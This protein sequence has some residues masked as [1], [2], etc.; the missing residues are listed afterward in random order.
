MISK[1]N[2]LNGAGIIFSDDSIGE[3]PSP[4]P[5]IGSTI[6]IS[7]APIKKGTIILRTADENA[8][9]QKGIDV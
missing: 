6:T 9:A 7:K 8:D 3:S 2:L 1:L 5:A 4:A